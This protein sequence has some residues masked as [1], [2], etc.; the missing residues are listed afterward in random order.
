[1]YLLAVAVGL[2]WASNAVGGGTVV[3]SMT[4][5]IVATGFGWR[6]RDELGVVMLVGF[7][8]AAMVLGAEL[9]LTANGNS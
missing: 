4:V 6:R 3:F 2:T 5:A 8:P 1:M 7:L 9:A